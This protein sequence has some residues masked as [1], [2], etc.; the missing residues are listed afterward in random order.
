[1][2]ETKIRKQNEFVV[3]LGQKDFNPDYLYELEA[4]RTKLIGVDSVR[5]FQTPYGSTILT[6]IV[7]SGWKT[8]DTY[9]M[10]E[11]LFNTLKRVGYRGEMHSIVAPNRARRHRVR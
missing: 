6:I 7:S 4:S 3:V 1:M 8:A 2:P 10:R 11:W 5:S 9:R